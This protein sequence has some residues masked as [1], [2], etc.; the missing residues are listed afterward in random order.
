MALSERLAYILDFNVAGAVK[1]LEKVG[2]TADRELGKA[3]KKLDKVAGNLTKFGAGAVA[4]AGI[5]GA[6]L[7]KTALSASDLEESVNAVNVTFGDAAAGILK[8]GE[9]AAHAVGLSNAEFN[10]LAVQFSSFATTVAGKGGDVVQTME[11]LT[12]RAADFASVMN[13]DVA[14]A[15]RVFQSGLA[16]E[17]EPLKKFGIDLSAASVSAY[18]AA[19]GIAEV[20]AKM[21]ET[22]KVQARYGL[23]MEAT[24]KTQGDFANTSDGY[25]N[26]MRIFK[27][28]LANLSA[29]IGSGVLPAL[30]KFAQ[31]AIKVTGALSSLNE[32]SG[33]SV[34]KF[35][36][37]GV[38][39]IGLLGT[40]S[41]IA[42]QVI[43]MRD[44][45][46]VLDKDGTRSL[47]NMGKAAKGLGIALGIAAAALAVYQ[48]AQ[49]KNSDD[50]NELA[51][52]LASTS[53]M[54]EDAAGDAVEALALLGKITGD[55]KPAI[56]Q[57]VAG[58][59][60]AAR[61]LL[62]TGVAARGGA[63][64]VDMLTKAVAAE[65]DARKINASTLE[66][67]GDALDGSTE[68]VEDN[69]DAVDGNV[70]ALEDVGDE[71]KRVEDATKRAKDENKRQYRALGDLNDEYDDLTGYL[72][73]TVTGT[74]DLTA[75][76]QE[77][78]GEISQRGAYRDLK[79]QFDAVKV[80]AEEAYIAAAE[81]SEDAES[82]S[83]DHQQAVD[84]LILEVLGYGTELGNLPDKV[85][86]EIVALIDQGKLDEA[87]AL[88]EWTA[89]QRDVQ[90][91]LRVSGQTI[92]DGGDVIG[93]RGG[94][95]AG[96]GPMF[97]GKVH[98]FAESGPELYQSGGKTWVVGKDGASA[99]PAE[100]VG[101]GGG[102]TF[103][104]QIDG[105]VYGVDHL[106]QILN[107][108]DRKLV[109]QLRQGRR[110]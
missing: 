34:G 2:S 89:R 32:K 110:G 41:L 51:D 106:Q 75:S 83:R 40:L 59:I 48:G 7:V 104:T 56:D 85:T 68:S 88:I 66:G 53:R 20:G 109:A 14:E 76:F 4:F 13:L 64:F 80:A 50:I 23:L 67:Y 70:T 74:D 61:R 79:D 22:E 99:R 62:A 27:A 92:T 38:A 46:S 15:A 24:V 91:R 57:F 9:D 105:N 37:L 98:E 100:E 49:K 107:E 28:D 25:A 52:G 78:R 81:G 45:F 43:K 30:A 12:G 8:L 87:E 97:S 101:G 90:L 3:E 108:R 69:T 71:T 10:G 11:D 6:A 16:G 102:H 47:N 1:G 5:A 54:T 73:A 65:T 29:E 17:T 84:D 36:A 39:G 19:N 31:A 72:Y 103:V 93:Q 63:D 26:S 94:A 33:G 82:K 96:G 58:N 77:L 42:G 44:R 21:T 18:A 35:A 86:A 55:I 60:E 95:R